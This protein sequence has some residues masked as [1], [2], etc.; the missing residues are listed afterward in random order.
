MTLDPSKEDA[1][2][3]EKGQDDHVSDAGLTLT[4]DDE[5]RAF[6]AAD[7]SWDPAEERALVRR[8]DL[9]IV[10][11]ITLLYLCN[12]ID[13]TNIGNAKVAGLEKDSKLVGYQYNIGLSVFYIVYA[14][15][16]VPSNLLLKRIGA[17]VWIPTL[18]LAF[19]GVC[20]A[21]A[22]IKNFGGFMAVRM[23][24]GLAEGGVM[25]GIAYYLS[26]WYTRDEL[27]LRIGIFVSASSLSG[28]FGG[29]LAT[30]FLSVHQIDG[31]PHGQWRN[32]FLFEG[33]ITIV[34]ALL[35]YVLLPRAPES[36]RFLSE[37]EKTIAMERLRTGNAGINA[38]EKTDFALIKRAF[39]NMNTMVC[40]VRFLL[41]NITVQGISLFMPTLL[42]GM[43]YKGIQSQLHTVPPYI[44]ASVWS[45]FVAY[46]C[47]RTSRRGIWCLITTPFAIL[48]SCMLIATSKRSV[49]YAG[50]F[51]LAMGGAYHCLRSF[52]D[53][54][55]PI[56]ISVPS[57][58]SL[59][60]MGHQ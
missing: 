11:L 13:R 27:A 40:A 57:W 37:R 15:T 7:V 12:F 50:I 54:L 49:G 29:L 60:D 58:T 25:P 10:P 51:F 4:S 56:F 26:M 59:L 43:G 33:V 24:L 55:N 18:V 17:T 35:G 34:V 2:S 1:S 20:V 30:A 48:G 53:R 6:A 8:L 5:K 47:Q 52:G 19:G 9:R 45:I 32:I 22:F 44:V 14:L 38:A 36:N 42:A 46:G 21:T 3:L 23:C 31:L 41:C 16:E 39:F 28:A